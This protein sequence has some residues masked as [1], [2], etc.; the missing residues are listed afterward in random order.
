MSTFNAEYWTLTLQW[1][2]IDKHVTE[3]MD[4]QESEL[5]VRQMRIVAES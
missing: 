5:S 4:E 2:Y 3:Q 1:M